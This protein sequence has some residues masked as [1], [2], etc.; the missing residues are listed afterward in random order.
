ML[1]GSSVYSD[2]ETTVTEKTVTLTLRDLGDPSWAL[3][4][5]LVAYLLRSLAGRARR[6]L[7]GDTYRRDNLGEELS[8]AIRGEHREGMFAECWLDRLA[9]RWGVALA[10]SGDDPFPLAAWLPEDAEHP[11]RRIPWHIACRKIRRTDLALL[12]DEWGSFLAAF[13]TSAEAEDDEEILKI[14]LPAAVSDPWCLPMPRAAIRP[15]RWVAVLHSTAA[16]AHGADERDGNT[17]RF[18]TERRYSWLLKRDV[19]LPFLSGNAFRGQIRDLVASDLCE[20]LGV[21]PR[22][23]APRMAHALFSGGS[24]EAGAVTAGAD[25]GYRKTLRSLVAAVDVM[26]G[27]YNDEVMDGMLRAGDMLPICRESA[28]FLAYDLVP[29]LVAKGE[30]SV[31]AWSE[32]L[33]WCEDLYV[34]RQLTRVRHRD[35]EGGDDAQA[36]VRTEC[37]RAGTQWVHGF[38]LAAKDRAVTPLARGAMAH[39]VDLFVRS[40]GVGAA[41]ARGLGTFV[42]DGYRHPAGE[43]IGDAGLYTAHVAEHRDAILGLLRAPP[44]A[45][46]PEKAAKGKGRAKPLAP[47]AA[48]PEGE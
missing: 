19:D 3:S 2:M 17:Q 48:L 31:R 45:P 38:G 9:S 34:T 1:R 35:F 11:R 8:A 14:D 13:A 26:G 40:G 16:L 42:T 24:I 32:R 12:A 25:T 30:E 20:R 21:D 46:P 37:I 15:S 22:E 33:P 4:T 7:E 47:L 23:L 39:I 6:E 43:A 44:K 41:T 18:R 29:D 10:G 36:I 27:V 5:R 28:C